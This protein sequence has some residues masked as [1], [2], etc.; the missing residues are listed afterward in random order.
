M[1]AADPDRRLVVTRWTQVLVRPGRGEPARSEAG[2]GGTG[3]SSGARSTTRPPGKE[4]DWE[5][6]GRGTEAWGNGTETR[7]ARANVFSD[8]R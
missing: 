2:R 4:R 1:P 3:Q 7:R 6:P 5:I 8:C